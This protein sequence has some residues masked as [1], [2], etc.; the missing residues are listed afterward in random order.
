MLI[1]KS[2]RVTCQ[3]LSTRMHGTV[4]N[5]SSAMDSVQRSQRDMHGGVVGTSV[6][7]KQKSVEVDEGYLLRTEVC[8]IS[9]LVFRGA[10]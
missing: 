6:L 8:S 2:C 10:E 7:R 3:R 9:E 4:E 1:E 5:M